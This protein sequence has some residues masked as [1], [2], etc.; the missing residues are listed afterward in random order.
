MTSGSVNCR[1]RRL[2]ICFMR[3]Q[4]IMSVRKIWPSMRGDP[5]G[6]A[7]T[8]DV[9][10][11]RL[12]RAERET[13]TTFSRGA[14]VMRSVRAP[15]ARPS[16][17]KSARMEYDPSSSYVM[18]QR[19]KV[20]SYSC[21]TEADPLSPAAEP[22]RASFLLADCFRP[23]ERSWRD[24]YLIPPDAAKRPRDSVAVMRAVMA[25]TDR[26]TA[27]PLDD[28]SWPMIQ[29]VRASRGSTAEAYDVGRLAR[30]CWE[31]QAAARMRDRHSD[32]PVWAKASPR[33]PLF[34]TRSNAFH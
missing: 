17:A 34:S 33:P 2:S 8:S 5:A 30:T 20:S 31:G 13:R 11:A 1:W 16:L 6:P 21:W 27:L 25:G 15:T 9:H 12:R 22:P 23:P 18:V 3:R 24:R 26:A 29:A 10:V 19:Q 28:L 4:A 32:A 7:S 14:M